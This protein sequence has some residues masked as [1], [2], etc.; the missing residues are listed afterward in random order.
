MFM[1]RALGLAAKAAEVGEV[2][3][4]AVVVLDGEVIGEGFNQPIL[5]SDPS[6]H[7]EV[8]AMRAAAHKQQ[9][10]RLPGATLYVTIEPCTMCFGTLIHAR[11]GR[12]VYGATE[13]RAGVITSQLQLPDQNFFNHKVQVEGGVMAEEAGALLKDFFRKRR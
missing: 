3:V 2:P 13:P 12:V 8:M 10:Y 11:I 6:A 7:A 9:N 1:Q 5:A 4:G